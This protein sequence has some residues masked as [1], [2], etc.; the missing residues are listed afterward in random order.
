ML[1][2]NYTFLAQNRQKIGFS[3][4]NVPQNCLLT[5]FPLGFVV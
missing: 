1:T 4:L 2:L 5:L 3:N